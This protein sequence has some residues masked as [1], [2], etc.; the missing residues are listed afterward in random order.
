VTRRGPLSLHAAAIQL[1]Q[2]VSCAQ[3]APIIG[4]GFGVTARSGP[5][6]LQNLDEPPS[7]TSL[8]NAARWQHAAA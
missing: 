1:R 4:E 8:H 6:Q 7:Q 3:E 5:A 2:S